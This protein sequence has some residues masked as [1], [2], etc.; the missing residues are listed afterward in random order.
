MVGAG[1]FAALDGRNESA[2]QAGT[3]GVWQLASYMTGLSGGSWFVGSLAIN[4]NP[5]IQELVLGSPTYQ[6][7]ALYFTRGWPA[8]T[9]LMIHNACFYRS[10]WFLEYNLVLP[11]GF[12]SLGDNQNYYGNIGANVNLKQDAGFNTSITDVGCS[13]TH[14]LVFC[15]DR[16]LTYAWVI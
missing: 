12:I 15:Y 3:G 14:P 9:A 8:T 10:R 13:A 16:L 2:V 5:P 7:C 1:T 6:G 4:S 11:D